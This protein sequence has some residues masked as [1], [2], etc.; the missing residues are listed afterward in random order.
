MIVMHDA[1]QFATTYDAAGG[2][3]RALKEWSAKNGV[4]YFAINERV[5]GKPGEPRPVYRDGCGL[6]LI[7][8]L[9]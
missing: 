7:Q 9:G 5:T 1:S 2:V 4:P 3:L 8:R 6:G